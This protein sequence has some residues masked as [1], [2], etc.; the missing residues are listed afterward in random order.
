[1]EHLHNCYFTA[2]FSALFNSWIYPHASIVQFLSWRTVSLFFVYIPF[3]MLAC[4]MLESS[5]QAQEPYLLTY[6]W[7]LPKLLLPWGLP[8]VWVFMKDMH[9]TCMMYR[10]F[11]VLPCQSVVLGDYTGFCWSLWKTL[12]YL[13]ICVNYVHVRRRVEVLAFSRWVLSI[14]VLALSNSNV[15]S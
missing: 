5:H 10:V 7:A 8:S 3:T 11:S 12:L 2:C 4:T 14:C 9:K 15:F 1:M 6:F 13:F